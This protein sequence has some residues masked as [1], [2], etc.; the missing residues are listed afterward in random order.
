MMLSI[1]IGTG[2]PWLVAL[3]SESR[4]RQLIA[5]SA[6]SLAGTMLGAFAFHWISPTYGIIA[7]ISVGP[8]ISLLAI[9]A[10]QRATRA[11]VSRVAQPPR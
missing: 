9:A 5:N 6:F 1:C 11:I 8:V 2:V 3:F 10:G 7:L 4:A